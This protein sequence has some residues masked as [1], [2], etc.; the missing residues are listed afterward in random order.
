LLGGSFIALCLSF[1]V[2]CILPLFAFIGGIVWAIFTIQYTNAMKKCKCPDSTAQEIMR[3]Y[4]IIRILGGI[5]IVLLLGNVLIDLSSLNEGDRKKV[6]SSVI[7][8]LKQR[9]KN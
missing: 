4:A 6:I 5:L 3:I 2:L 8:K 1:P 7:K 9:A